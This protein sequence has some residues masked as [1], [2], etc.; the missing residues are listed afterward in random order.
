MIAMW[1]V[2]QCVSICWPM[3]IGESCAL[4]TEVLPNHVPGEAA[5]VSQCNTPPELWQGHLNHLGP[6]ISSLSRQPVLGVPFNKVGRFPK[7]TAIVLSLALMVDKTASYQMKGY[8]VSKSDSL[9]FSAS[10]ASS[11]CL[12]S[13]LSCGVPSNPESYTYAGFRL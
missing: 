13:L 8:L 10:A 1:S 2:P 11:F 6:M 7:S 5:S 12:T 3:E 9:A 4:N